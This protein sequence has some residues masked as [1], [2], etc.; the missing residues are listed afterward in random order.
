MV[1]LLI[2]A[3][4]GHL[5]IVRLLVQVPIVMHRQ[6]S[7]GFGFGFTSRQSPNDSLSDEAL[8]KFPGQQS[9]LKRDRG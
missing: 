9:P 3:K 5:N 8:G 6:R 4:E 2:A 1:P 7:N